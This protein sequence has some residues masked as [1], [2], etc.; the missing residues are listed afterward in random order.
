VKV[1]FDTNVLIAAFVSEGICAKL[2]QRA[3]KKQFILASCPFLL[4]E[5]GR[6]LREKF[7]A[8]R[9]EIRNAEELISE[10]IQVLVKPSQQVTGVCRDTDD[11]MVLACALAAEADYLVT[12]DLDL[13]VLG[14]FRGIDI[15]TPRDFE[16]L[17]RD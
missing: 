9:A 14:N 13:Q 12:G 5:A 6:V 10:A 17:F 2:L 15:I 4:Q 11:D 16:S 7:S 1:V 3:R 8:T